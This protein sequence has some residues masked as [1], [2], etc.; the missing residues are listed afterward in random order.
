ML[1]ASAYL[2][3]TVIEARISLGVCDR[4]LAPMFLSGG[5]VLSQVTQLTGLEGYIVQN[6]VKRGYVSRPV[7]KKY[8]R[9]QFCRMLNI[10]VLKDSFSFEESVKIL[11]YVNGG[12]SEEFIDDSM[13]YACFVDLLARI[14]ENSNAED[15]VDITDI[16][17]KFAE[18]IASESGIIKNKKYALKRLN[19]VLNIMVTSYK[20]FCIKNKAIGMFSAMDYK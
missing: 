19:T 1:S 6:W 14:N 7:S 13:L 3:G 16:T 4:I 8:T 10:N 12:M 15:T 2:P 9:C 11:S 17:L 18:E 20:S 5:L